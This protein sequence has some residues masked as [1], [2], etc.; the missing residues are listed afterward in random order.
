MS[1]TTPIRYHKKK[2]ELPIKQIYAKNYCQIGLKITYYRKL[3]GLTQEDLAE[4]P[5]ITARYIL[6]KN[7]IICALVIKVSLIKNYIIK[8][9]TSLRI[10]NYRQ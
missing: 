4:H 3:R 5:P 8:I 10:K 1:I 7:K 9:I 6:S 2:E